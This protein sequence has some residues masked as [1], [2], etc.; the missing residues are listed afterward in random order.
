MKNI[1]F[2]KYNVSDERAVNGITERFYY[3]VFQTFSKDTV[4]LILEEGTAAGWI[5]L[6]LPESSLYSDF[7]CT[8]S[9]SCLVHDGNGIAASAE[10]IREQ[11]VSAVFF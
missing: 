2:R 8:D 3:E 4:Q 7:G 1:A 6:S 11:A 9:N 5:H 10:G